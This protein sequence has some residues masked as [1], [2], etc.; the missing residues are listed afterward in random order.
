MFHL[1]YHFFGIIWGV[2]FFL[3]TVLAFL[4]ATAALGATAPEKRVTTPAKSAA[5]PAK[6]AETPKKQLIPASEWKMIR[7]IA[8]NYDLSNEATW[9]LAAIRRHENGRP[10]L[11]FGVGGPMD[12]GHKAHRYRDGVKSFYVQGYWAAGTIRKHYTGD[13]TAFGRRYNPPHAA[14]WTTAVT[15]LIKRLKA[16]NNSKLP[17]EK[18]AKK[19][20]SLP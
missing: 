7:Q 15:S 2:K 5:T 20:I 17:G 13:L 12:S 4:A 19:V 1:L 8:V 6:P 3:H 9:L 18:P 11:E 14:K 16:E 10:G